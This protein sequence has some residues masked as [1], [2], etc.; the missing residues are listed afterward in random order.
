MHCLLKVMKLEGNKK[1]ALIGKGYLGDTLASCAGAISLYEEKGIKVDFYCKWK[2]LI[3]ILKQDTRFNTIYYSKNFLG[4][5][6]FY[7]RL[8]KYNTIFEAPESWSY[9]EPFT[10][11]IRRIVKCKAKKSFKINLNKSLYPS[12]IRKNQIA[13]SRDLI[14]RNFGRD[15]SELTDIL[16]LQK[17]IV[18]VGLPAGKSS[19]RGKNVDLSDTV[20]KLLSSEVYIGPE[21]G[22]LWL[23]GSIGVSTLYFSEQIDNVN[24][25]LKKGN[26]WKTLGSENIFG[27]KNHKCIPAYC[28]NKEAIKIIYECI[29]KNHF[30]NFH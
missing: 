11:Q 19:K 21:G 22:L 7:F 18:W 15:I 23:A 27:K 16:S 2:Q 14:S 17:K 30:I 6:I 3:P 4:R 13:I 29:S 8:K 24:K 20:H 1:T 9:K 25:K 5:I 10:C 12:N 26:A 28:S